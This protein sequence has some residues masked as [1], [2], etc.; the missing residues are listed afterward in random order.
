MIR[1]MKTSPPETAFR[2]LRTVSFSDTDA[3]GFVHFTALLRYVEDAEH[4]ALRQAGFPVFS[5]DTGWPR[6]HMDADFISPAKF[7]D[8][9]AILVW[10][11]N[12]GSSSL[13]WNF[14][15][16]KEKESQNITTVQLTCVRMGRDKG[17][18][19]FSLEEK[20]ALLSRL[21]H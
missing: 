2:A 7:G 3:A 18:R 17:S 14:L 21:P 15:I 1:K 5:Q 20:S 4:Q 16:R 8:T 6:V 11:D 10:L 13:T 12:I 9:L 19:P